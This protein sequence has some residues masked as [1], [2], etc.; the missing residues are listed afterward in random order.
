MTL[1]QHQLINKANQLFTYFELNHFN[2][3]LGYSRRLNL[4]LE[5]CDYM[6][7]K[8]DWE[9]L[10]DLDS[11]NPQDA[12]NFRRIINQGADVWLGDLI[13]TVNL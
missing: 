7:Q 1:S 4:V 9:L 11:E 12:T 8:A 13:K 3:E 10:A 6:Q 2:N 5:F